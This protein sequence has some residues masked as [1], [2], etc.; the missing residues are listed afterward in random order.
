MLRQAPELQPPVRPGVQM[1]ARIRVRPPGHSTPDFPP[2][3]P[4]PGAPL[5]QGEG[6][7][8]WQGAGAAGRGG[9]VHQPHAAGPGSPWPS[10][11]PPPAPLP[12]P[13]APEGGP[14][15]YSRASRK[16]NYSPGW[17]P[18]HRA[19]KHPG[20]AG[21]RLR[22]W[23]WEEGASYLSSLFLHTPR[24]RGAG[25]GRSSLHFVPTQITPHPRSRTHA[26][27]PGTSS[28]TPPAGSHLA[29]GFPPPWG[30]SQVGGEQRRMLP[31]GWP[32]CWAGR[33]H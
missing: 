11:P 6:Q 12:G 20:R 15:N 7:E 31:E 13:R 10:P 32:T 14:G 25:L 4:V 29:L 3:V 19:G 8:Q 21:G 24:Q 2:G 1:P 27:C 5:T 17:H 9:P 33:Q 16:R 28:P 18:G 22:E 30:V 23:G 26:G